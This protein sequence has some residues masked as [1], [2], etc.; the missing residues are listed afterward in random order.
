MVKSTSQTSLVHCQIGSIKNMVTPQLCV[1]QR[2]WLPT[3]TTIRPNLK[4][5]PSK[6]RRALT[7]VTLSSP[8]I[9]QI[10]LHNTISAPLL[11]ASTSSCIIYE[12]RPAAR[13]ERYT[14]RFEGT[15]GFTRSFSC[16]VSVT[17]ACL[18]PYSHPYSHLRFETPRIM[19]IQVQAGIFRHGFES[20]QL[21]VKHVYHVHY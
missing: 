18:T 7:A 6:S 15:C 12:M 16:F 1:W 20:L 19:S 11:T 21:C 4:Q 9:V 8:F 13:E 17:A 14:L 5:E 10:S 2:V 3:M